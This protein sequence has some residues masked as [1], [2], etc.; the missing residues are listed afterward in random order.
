MLAKGP[1]QRCVLTNTAVGDYTSA[2]DDDWRRSD[3]CSEVWIV[4]QK[5]KLSGQKSVM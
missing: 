1:E 2:A 4:Q 3:K 5:V